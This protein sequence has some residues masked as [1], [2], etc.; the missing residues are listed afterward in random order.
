M[1]QRLWGEQIVS[2]QLIGDNTSG[3]ENPNFGVFH[4]KRRPDPAGCLINKGLVRSPSEGMSP[5]LES[6]TLDEFLLIP[7]LLFK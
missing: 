4:A 3:S 1:Q 2:A 7:P 6:S 5:G